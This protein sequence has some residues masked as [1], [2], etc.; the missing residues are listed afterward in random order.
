MLFF[1][2]KSAIEWCDTPIGR[3][4]SQAG[5]SPFKIMK[6]S[7]KILQILFTNDE[8]YVIIFKR[9]FLEKG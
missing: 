7:L 5:F 4:A 8:K 9:E 1:A 3:T 6:I 2:E